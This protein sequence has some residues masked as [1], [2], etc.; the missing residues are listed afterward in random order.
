MVA[1]YSSASEPPILAVTEEPMRGM[2]RILVWKF[3]S[4]K[5][6][7]ELWKTI[8]TLEVHFMDSICDL[9]HCLLATVAPSRP[10]AIPGQVVIWR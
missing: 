5:G 9:T 2:S 4:Q 7:Y 6:N 8:N 1:G 3:S 10:A